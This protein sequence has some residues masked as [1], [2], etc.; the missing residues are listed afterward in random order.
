MEFCHCGKQGCRIP[1]CKP[2]AG[3]TLKTHEQI[4]RRS[5][6]KREERLAETGIVKDQVIKHFVY[7]NICHYSKSVMNFTWRWFWWWF[8][9]S[10][11]VLLIPAVTNYLHNVVHVFLFWGA[12]KQ[13]P[14]ACHKVS[15]SSCFNEKYNIRKQSNFI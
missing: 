9:S 12:R 3:K 6:K 1:M 15:H 7:A 10:P 5:E 8:F 11:P 2:E 14:A 4:K 13:T